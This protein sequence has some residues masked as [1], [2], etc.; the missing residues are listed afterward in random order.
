MGWSLTYQIGEKKVSGP[1]ISADSEEELK[2]AKKE[3]A[4]L[5]GQAM[6]RNYEQEQEQKEE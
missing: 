4:R 2:E 6:A 1:Q 3:A 5:W